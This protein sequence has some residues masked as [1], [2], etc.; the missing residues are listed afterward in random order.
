M[1][2][3]IMI[4]GTPVGGGEPVVVQSMCN[5]KT[6]DVDATVAQIR[7]LERAGC[8]IV[9]FAVPDIESAEAIGDIKARTKLPLVADIHFDHRL[10]IAAIEKGIDKLRIN[11][12][13]IGGQLKVRELARAAKEAG[14][15][16]RIGVNAGS[17]EKALLKRYGGPTAEA[18]AESALSHAA[19]LEAEGFEDIVLSIK[20]S[21]VRTM[22]EANRA[23]AERC[24]YPLHIG[25]TEAG[26]GIDCE[27][28]SAVG[29]GTLLMEGI[30]DTIRVS[31]TGDPVREVRAA[32][33]I[34]NA[35]G[36]RRRGIELISCPTCART[37]GDMVKIAAEI[38]RRLPKTNQTLK[39][40]IMGCAV[41]GPGEAREADVGVAF[42]P[43]KCVLFSHGKVIASVPHDK[44]AD[45]LLEQIRLRLT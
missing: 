15:P 18:L 42:G 9:R 24:D 40:A 31:M 20:A 19:L 7:R 43:T 1:R 3:K 16:I 12:G 6:A 29:I 30:G 8:E 32:W 26:S 4:R 21:D 10:A 2:K 17:L 11:P 35:S 38:K 25:V 28:K 37:G 45:A 22:V 5:T 23:L 36:V 14:V 41:N 44:A 39:V 27:V 34:L 13:N 33:R